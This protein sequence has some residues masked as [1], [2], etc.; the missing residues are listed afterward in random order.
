MSTE[1]TARHGTNPV[2][3]L[4]TEANEL[5]IAMIEQIKIIDRQLGETNWSKMMFTT[6][7]SDVFTGSETSPE[8]VALKV[9]VHR[10]KISKA[11][12]SQVY[13]LLNQQPTT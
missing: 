12:L 4:I 6:R 3:D 13:G 8:V 2:S 9:L 1:N 11:T 10:L 7:L 5:A